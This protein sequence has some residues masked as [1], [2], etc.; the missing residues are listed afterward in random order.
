MN[1]GINKEDERAT[2]NPAYVRLSVTH[3]MHTKD[4]ILNRTLC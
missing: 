3:I 4:P 2:V 1:I